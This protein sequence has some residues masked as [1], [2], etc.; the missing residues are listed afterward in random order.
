MSNKSYEENDINEIENIK[1]L[2]YSADIVDDADL[3][4]VIEGLSSKS[5]DPNKLSIKDL[6]LNFENDEDNNE[7]DSDE[8]IEDEVNSIIFSVED[9]AVKLYLKDVLNETKKHGI[10]TREEE[11]KLAPKIKARDKETLKLLM[12]SNLRLVIHNAKKFSGRGI[13]MDE[14]IQE[15]NLGLCIAAQKFDP[16]K[17]FKFST[18]ATWWI[19]QR[20][21]KMIVTRFNIIRV[22]PHMI[23]KIRTINLAKE[24]YFNE[25]K[26]LPTKKQLAEMTGLSLKTIKSAENIP[27]GVINLDSHID[28]DNDTT[29][30]EIIENKNDV[31]V[32]SQVSSKID[33]D[34]LSERAKALLSEKEIYILNKYFFER[35]SLQEIG[36]EMGRTRER[37]RQIKK[38]A[39]EKLRGDSEIIKRF[40]SEFG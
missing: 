24:K 13:S 33:R 17:G 12:A 21:R 19:L 15:G 34:F 1:T 23:Y 27:T 10:M 30:G 6:E 4:V 25:H 14:L 2:L 37:V 35:K 29:F 40:G 9:T 28:D 5:I 22:P 18:Y 38:E 39:L 32:E 26:K 16:D 3:D 8:D 31:S 7:S 20:I 11:L 36:N